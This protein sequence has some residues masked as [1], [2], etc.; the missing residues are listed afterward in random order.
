M[1]REKECLKGAPTTSIPAYFVPS[2][3]E[4]CAKTIAET[5]ETQDKV[6]ALK[7]DPDT[8]ELYRLVVD[9]LSTDLKLE[10][11]VRR[12]N[13]QDYWR[14]RCEARWSIGALVEF[15]RGKRGDQL[16]GGWKQVYLQRHLEEYLM[17]LP[18]NPPASSSADEGKEDPHSDNVSHQIVH[19]C[20]VCGNWIRSLHLTH[21]GYHFNVELLISKLPGLEELSLTYGVSNIAIGFKMEMLKMRPQDAVWIQSALRSSTSLTSLTLAGNGIDNELLRAIV[22]GLVSNTKLTYLDV[23]S[24]RIDDDGAV[25]LGTLLMKKGY[26]LE[27]LLVNDNL[28]RE[29]G[30][31]ALGRALTVNTRLKTL[32]LKLN[33]LGDV[34]GQYL[35]DGVKSNQSL[36]SLNL[37]SNELAAESARALGEALRGNRT[38]VE[39][40]VAGNMLEE[41]GGRIIVNSVESTAATSA[42]LVRLDVRYSGVDP[43]DEELIAKALQRRIAQQQSQ[44]LEAIEQELRIK[45]QRAVAEKI[46]RTHGVTISHQ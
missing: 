21:Q 25:A 8:Y 11:A 30:G 43:R 34:G 24:N 6:D 17:S 1:R 35:I 23:S 42:A 22:A 37:G 33:R 7:D 14:A 10:E 40:D 13:E 4:I 38:L 27:T 19:L 41:D 18:P 12:V 46:L 15:T 20:T 3:K 16:P 5:F 36:T 44:K 45:T 31:K 32:N 26:Q 39:V 29:M 2:L 28:I 9:Q